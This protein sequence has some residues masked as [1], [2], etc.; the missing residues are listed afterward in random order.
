[1]LFSPNDPRSD[2]QQSG[3]KEQE[4]PRVGHPCHREYV[5]VVLVNE[6]AG[7]VDSSDEAL[8]EARHI[9]PGLRHRVGSSASADR[10]RRDAELVETDYSRERVAHW[11]RGGVV[12]RS[13]VDG[14]E[15]VSE[16]ER[17]RV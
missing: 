14:E 16:G 10:P 4:R 3:A 13:V 9:Q 2:H 5:E 17:E 15:R 7:R 6:A 8:S 12:E 1:L 11:Y